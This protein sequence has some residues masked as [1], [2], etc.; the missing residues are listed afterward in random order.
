MFGDLGGPTGSRRPLSPKR[1]FGSAPASAAGS[2]YGRSQSGPSQLA[3]THAFNSAANTASAMFSR[4]FYP[5]ASADP[6]GVSGSISSSLFNS[7]LA[8]GGRAPASLIGAQLV[9]G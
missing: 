9:D 7:Q 1:L 8:G 2:P 6:Y 5:S 3:T 4:P